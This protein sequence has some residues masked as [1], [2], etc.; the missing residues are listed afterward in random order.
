MNLTGQIISKSRDL[1]LALTKREWSPY[2]IWCGYGFPG[3]QHG[4]FSS[5]GSISMCRQIMHSRQQKETNPNKWI[6]FSKLHW[7]CVNNIGWPCQ[8]PTN[9]STTYCGIAMW[10]LTEAKW[11]MVSVFE[12]LGGS[13]RIN[14][15]LKEKKAIVSYWDDC[16]FGDNCCISEKRRIYLWHRYSWM[17]LMPDSLSPAV[18][19]S[20][21]KTQFHRTDIL[22]LVQ[23]KSLALIS[24]GSA[25]I[26]WLARW[27]ILP[28]PFVTS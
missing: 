19:N 12:L 26:E 6:E 27:L 8:T 15:R 3:S 14:F 18:N 2:L 13:F 5:S 1:I 4:G 20:S 16:I 21:E 17:R 11:N 23:N 28:L 9:F 22:L 24:S 10:K 25:V 7:E